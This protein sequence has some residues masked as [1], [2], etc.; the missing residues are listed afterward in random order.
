VRPPIL[1]AT[2][3]CAGAAGGEEDVVADD[4]DG[5]D[6]GVGG[7]DGEGGA[8]LYPSGEGRGWSGLPGRRSCERLCGGADWLWCLPVPGQQLVDAAGGVAGKAGE[9]VG[10]PGAGIDAVQLRRF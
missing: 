10:E 5:A 1:R 9:D 3:S 7:E 2:G 6:R 4:G 8:A